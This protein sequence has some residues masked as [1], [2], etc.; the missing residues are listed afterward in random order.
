MKS[1]EKATSKRASRMSTRLHV[2]SVLNSIDYISKLFFLSPFKAISK[3][4][5]LPKWNGMTFWNLWT[6]V[7]FFMYVSFHLSYVS[8]N[9]NGKDR[10]KLVTVFI[11]M[12]NK[13]CGLLLNGVLVV[14]G[15]FQQTNIANINLVFD[16]I[17]EIFLKQMRIKIKNLNTMR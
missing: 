8:Q 11:D 2:R 7:G 1:V 6:I 9:D 14:T 10:L 5:P 3:R 17:E 15:Y 12:Y 4:K 13:Y 16:D